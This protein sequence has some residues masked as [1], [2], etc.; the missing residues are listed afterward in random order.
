MSNDWFP[1]RGRLYYA[2]LDKW[3]PALVISV[4][5]RNML[6]NNIILV[7]CSTRITIA[8]THVQLRKGEGGV[9]ARSVL[10]CEQITT[11][12]KEL[13]REQPLGP[14]LS[15]AQVEEVERN[16]LRAIG[17]NIPLEPGQT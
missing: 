6:A 1:Q 7:P 13:L 8:P 16:I 14:P 4:N 2:H 15:A 3:R 11:L 5:A 17:V 10:K 12:A 9:R